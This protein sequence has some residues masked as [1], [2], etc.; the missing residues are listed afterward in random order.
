MT[1]TIGAAQTAPDAEPAPTV[2]APPAAGWWRRNRWGLLGVIVLLPIGLAAIFADS[3]LGYFES[4]PSRAVV[5]G[6]EEAVQ[7]PT[8]A[9]ETIASA[10]LPA[11][12]PGAVD[13]PAGTE[14]VLARLAVTPATAGV[15]C[16]ITLAAVDG[17][18]E[19]RPIGAGEYG[20][21]PEEGLANGAC[22]S[23]RTEP[24]SV[25]LAFLVPQTADADLELVVENVE[26]FPEYL[27][28]RLPPPLE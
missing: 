21:S 6:A 12:T 22:D 20:W 18:G 5:A 10:R 7:M 19:W 16:E 1:E 27:R 24:Y 26:W 25:D 13:M 28:I 8:A 9:F 14:L 4:R 11:D 17:V 15:L 2:A 23:A 3:W